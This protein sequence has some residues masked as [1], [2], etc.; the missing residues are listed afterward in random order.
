[1]RRPATKGN[2]E[3]RPTYWAAGQ[4]FNY[5]MRLHHTSSA[6]VGWGRSW[7]WDKVVSGWTKSAKIVP[8][9]Y[10]EL[11]LS[12]SARGM[13]VL[14]FLAAWFGLVEFFTGAETSRCSSICRV[15]PGGG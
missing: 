3:I 7:E 10:L 8:N 2:A 1:M 13:S 15:L 9:G 6:S 4:I 14:T 11:S 5:R 12:H